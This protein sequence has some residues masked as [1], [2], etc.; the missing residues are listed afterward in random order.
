M[1]TS[2]HNFEAFTKEP[3]SF[4]NQTGDWV[5]DFE[6][7]FSH[8]EL[9]SFYSKM[10]RAR[11]LDDRF[12]TLQRMGKLSFVAPLA[13][14]EAAHVAVATA[15]TKGTDWLFP[16]Y[17][18]YGM[19]HILGLSALEVFAQLTGSK[20]DTAKGR[21]MPFHPGSKEL[22]IYTAISAIAAHIPPAVGVAMSMKLRN[23]GQVAIASFGDGATSEGDFHTAINYAGAQGAPVVF[24]CQNN[25]LA[26]SVDFKKQTGSETIHEKAKAYG[27][28][29]YYVDGMD[30]IA[31]HLVMK[32]VIERARSGVGPA[33]VEALV[34]RYGPHS[35][36]DDD[37][38]YRSQ[39]ELELWK[40]RDPIL[41]LKLYLEKQGVWT[42]ALEN[43]L[44]EDI[45]QELNNALELVEEAGKAPTE[46]MFDDVFADMPQHLI[47]QKEELLGE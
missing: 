21:Q 30:V 38:V 45:T 39:D 32:E 29:G 13:G 9:L 35:S 27:M 14:H 33:L 12:M 6:L 46:W 43:D 31:T 36:A 20:L 19:A 37:S 1:L 16:Y 3:I 47:E 41:R 18:D 25:R 22:N 26:I 8:D 11:L 4:L 17:R 23:T 42:Q 15:M 5:A 7:P 44:K 40:K 34:Y 2:T 28:P 24:V 10:L